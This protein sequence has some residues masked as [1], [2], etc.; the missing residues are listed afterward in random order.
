M[1]KS[2]YEHVPVLYLPTD[3]HQIIKDPVKRATFEA[4]R[5]NAMR[6]AEKNGL[7]INNDLI[8]FYI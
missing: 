2:E 7:D 4:S 1:G 8:N 5:D 6:W 3:L